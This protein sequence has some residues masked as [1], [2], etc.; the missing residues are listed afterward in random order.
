V[1]RS[2]TRRIGLSLSKCGATINE[3]VSDGIGLSNAEAL[4]DQVPT[5]GWAMAGTSDRIPRRGADRSWK[6]TNL[7]EGIEGATGVD[8]CLP[9]LRQPSNCVARA[10]NRLGDSPMSARKSLSM[11]A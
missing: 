5:A 4:G 11:C 7:L 3:K 9:Q 10:T 6:A 8:T 1:P 2:K